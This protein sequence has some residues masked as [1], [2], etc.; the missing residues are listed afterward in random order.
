VGEGFRHN[1]Q[2]REGDLENARGGKK[3]K[4]ASGKKSKIGLRHCTINKIERWI[5]STSF[6][7]TAKGGEIQTEEFKEKRSLIMNYSV[8]PLMGYGVYT[9]EQKGKMVEG[10]SCKGKSSI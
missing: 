6:D 9:V 3:G 2:F 10:E 4:R 5:L 1:H 7:G 8:A